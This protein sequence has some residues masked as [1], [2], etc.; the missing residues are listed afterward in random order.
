[1]M[2]R[3]GIILSVEAKVDVTNFIQFVS[4]QPVD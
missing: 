2:Y 3:L 1:M 4:P